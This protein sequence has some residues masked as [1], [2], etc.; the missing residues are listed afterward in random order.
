MGQKHIININLKYKNS[1]LQ[2]DLPAEG[3]QTYQFTTKVKELNKV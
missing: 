3:K 1:F 2:I